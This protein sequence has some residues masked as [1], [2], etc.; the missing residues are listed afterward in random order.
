MF[1]H[2]TCL[3]SSHLRYQHKDYPDMIFTLAEVTNEHCKFSHKPLFDEEMRVLVDFA[4]V[5]A[6]KATKR[7]ASTLIPEGVMVSK[8]LWKTPSWV[9]EQKKIYTQQV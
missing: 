3:I 2:C 1:H 9:A 4:N 8:L 5:K 6:W 7:H